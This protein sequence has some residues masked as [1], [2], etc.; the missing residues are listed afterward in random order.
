M[1]QFLCFVNSVLFGTERHLLM[2]FHENSHKI[3]K[4]QSN[5]HLF[6]YNAYIE[7][8]LSKYNDPHKV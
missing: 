4:F 3:G 5:L 6:N 8:V 2:Y 7:W 1:G